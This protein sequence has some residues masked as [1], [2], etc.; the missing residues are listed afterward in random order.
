MNL[1]P[2][3]FAIEIPNMLTATGDN[4]T[5]TAINLGSYGTSYEITKHDSDK[6]LHL[7][8]VDDDLI[9]MV[10]YDGAG[11]TL[12]SGTLFHKA[13]T[14]ITTKELTNLITICFQGR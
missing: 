2:N 12:A 1:N 14:N 10:L 6:K 9:D 4:Y 5:T 8:P 11:T 3:T 7:T 13:T